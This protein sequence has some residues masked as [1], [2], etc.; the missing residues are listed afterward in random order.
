MVTATQPEP[1][2]LH[3]HT[4]TGQAENIEG[5]CSRFSVFGSLWRQTLFE[6]KQKA[7]R[8][9]TAEQN[10]RVWK[11]LPQLRQREEWLLGDV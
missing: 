9:K 1:A 2:V 4:N 8:Q 11:I 3:N 7:A 6:K 5:W 10:W